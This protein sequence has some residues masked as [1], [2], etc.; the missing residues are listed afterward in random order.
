MNVFSFKTIHIDK[1]NWQFIVRI[2]GYCL[3]A[4]SK[5]KNSAWF[6]IFGSG[7]KWKHVSQ[8]LLFSERYG[9][10]K[11]ITICNWRV[12]LLKKGGV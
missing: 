3:F 1:N 8:T 9:Y 6:R 7:L 5:S 11:F 12:F 2:F 10:R 4:F